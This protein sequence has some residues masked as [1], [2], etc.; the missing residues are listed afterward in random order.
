MPERKR[1]QAKTDR[2]GKEE[3]GYERL[4]FFSDAVMAIAITLLALEVRLPE[5]VTDPSQLSAALLEQAPSIGAYFLSFFVIGV[6]WIG[7]HRMFTHIVRYDSGLLWINMFF[8]AFIALLPFPTSVL[9]RFAGDTTAVQFYAGAVTLIA[10]FRTWIWLHAVN[11]KLI[12]PKLTRQQIQRDMFLGVLTVLVFLI[13]IFIANF[14][15]NAAMY[16][17]IILFLIAVVQRRIFDRPEE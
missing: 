3:T 4:V 16:S 8:L 2:T 14:N 6:F 17:W 7:H 13:S 12:S 5:A 11:R 1:I 15:A 10:V 9:G